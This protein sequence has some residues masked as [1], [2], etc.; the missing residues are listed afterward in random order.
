MMGV[1][2]TTGLSGHFPSNYV[3]RCRESDCWA[4]H[5]YGLDHVIHHVIM[6]YTM[7]GV[8]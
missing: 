3:E 5:R 6:Y 7:I 8:I 1:S 2:T 4:L